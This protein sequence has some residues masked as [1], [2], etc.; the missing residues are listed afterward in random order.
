[1]EPK[2]L[3]RVFRRIQIVGKASYSISLPKQWVL[4]RG[5]KPGDFIE[6]SEALDGSLRLSPPEARFRQHSCRINADL[7]KDEKRL[8][9]LVV[10]GYRVGY[11][12]I[13]IS[14]SEK[15]IPEISKGLEDV[16]NA[17]PGLE[18][19]HEK[20]SKLVIRNVLDYTR[21]SI[22][23]LVKRCYLQ[24]SEIFNNI[25]H[26]LETGRYDLIPYIESLG[27][28][29]HELSQ[30]HTRLMITYLKR[31]EI[32]RSLR[33]RNPTHVYSSI[34][35]VMVI[36]WLVEYLIHLTR[37]ISRFRKKIWSDS[38]V[39]DVV[40][41]VLL[42]LSSLL[43]K[44]FNSYLSL[45]F[46]Q[47]N[48]V[49]SISGDLLTGGFREVFMKAASKDRLFAEFLAQFEIICLNIR[50]LMRE[51]AQLSLDLFIESKSPVCEIEE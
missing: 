9:K 5:L 1:M 14:S 51:I 21:F 12:V 48:K 36:R 16:V 30:L 27:D 26:F 11:D 40:R 33:F 13:Y 19:S 23:D 28:R 2:T 24:A 41:S 8:Q 42:E 35:I 15:S 7:C 45:E 6:I 37:L 4:S 39:Y 49:L 20:D 46:D 47:A 22:D 50:S 43:D 31:R 34:V 10:A 3:D 32:G 44:S 17:L 18:I 29:L 25:L 38:R